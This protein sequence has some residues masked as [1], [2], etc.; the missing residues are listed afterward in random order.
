MFN[1][2]LVQIGRFTN[3]AMTSERR[4]HV[5]RA[6]RREFIHLLLNLLTEYCI[7]LQTVS[8]CSIAIAPIIVILTLLIVGL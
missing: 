7:L 4:I 2:F 1:V 8:F 3:Q 5:E 6:F